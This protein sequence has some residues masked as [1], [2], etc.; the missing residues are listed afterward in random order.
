M[1]K[2][3]FVENSAKPIG[4]YSQ[5]IISDNMVYTSGQLGVIPETSKL[6][7]DDFK[8]EAEQVMKNLSAVLEGAG[9]SMKNIVKIT[10]LMQDLGQFGIVN[11][12]F[13][14]YFPE[15]PPA[16]STYQVAGLPLGAKVEIEAIAMV[17]E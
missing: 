4:P 8:T 13:K 14:E 9:S 15:N 3:V 1:R 10:V 16:R 11:D 12:I 5:A 7:T 17:K 6:I 2:V